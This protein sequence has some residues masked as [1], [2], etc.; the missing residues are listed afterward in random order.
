MNNG[1]FIS[2]QPFAQEDD[3]NDEK[4]NEADQIKEFGSIRTGSKFPIHCL[5]V[6]GQIEGH[7]A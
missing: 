2:P 3:D 4:S 1:D 7:K 5:T 6:I